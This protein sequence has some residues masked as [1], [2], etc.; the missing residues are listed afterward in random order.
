ML[1]SVRNALK[2]V[3]AWFV[4]ILLV[5]AFALFGVPE[6]RSFTQGAAIRVGDQSVSTNR[7]LSEFNR[8]LINQ[9]DQT[10][11]AFTREDAIATGLPNQIVN[12]LA[13]RS[14]VQQEAEKLGLAMPR[15]LVRELL[16]QNEQF[17]NPRTGKFDL[18]V[19]SGILRRYNLSVRDFEQEMRETFLRQQF[20][21]SIGGGGF[22]PATFADALLLR[23]IE[24][25]KITYLTMT[26]EM[27]GVPGEP[28]PE[29]LREFYEAHPEDFTAPEYR[30]FTVVSLKRSEFAEGLE[31]P[32]DELRRLYDLQ[33]DRLFNIPER[34]TIYLVPYDSE[35]A[36]I[37]AVAALKQGEP[38]EKI[39]EER[40]VSLEAVTYTEI[41]RTSL[42]D[43]AVAEAAFATDLGEGDV[44]EPIEG[45]Y[46]WNVIQVA[47]VLA[48]EVK[49]FEDVRDDIEA[50]YLEQDT[51]KRVY[52]AVDAI[53]EGRDA[54]ADLTAA[55]EAAD[56]AVVKHGPVDSFSFAPGGAIVG[57]IE[58]EVLAEAFRMEEG[59][60]TEAIEYADGSGYYFI[61]LDEVTPPAV[62]PFET[63]ETEVD[64]RWRMD[65]RE[66]RIKRAVKQVEDALAA[67]ATFAEAAA[68]FN[69]E[70]TTEVVPRKRGEGPF[71][72]AM[73]TRV[74]TADKG[75]VVIG[76]ARLG[77]EQTI[78]VIEEIDFNRASVGPGQDLAFKQY[79]GAQLD[80]EF[81][82]AYI[83]ALQ[84]DYDV[85][86]D[87]EQ[88]N[89]LFAVEQ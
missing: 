35:E 80:Q 49:T 67:G 47:G 85:R 45:L 2:G 51:Q 10:E 23:E 70:P 34:R 77:D 78:A 76:P 15:D 52:D 21:S 26:E 60:E 24:E 27:A 37:S 44:S 55:A 79:V 87:Q 16:S 17:Q 84:A 89:A 9:R 56:F 39:A 63:A 83:E 4:I 11:G 29:S 54:G 19:L 75:A 86:I 22:A 5:L 73:L 59:D 6:L 14:L 61:S 82:E 31:A 18:E 12:S 41:D 13:T 66:R 3:V 57:R 69:T 50:A 30:T 20:L 33:K 74:F 40:G 53:E 25:R 28:T 58:G 42:L 46:G 71:S 72:D 32:E 7:V 81:T 8:A 48:P 64:T 88:I 38:I 36:A 68:P 43:P 1:S 65:E 62:T